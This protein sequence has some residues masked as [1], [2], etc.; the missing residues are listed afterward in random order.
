MSTASLSQMPYFTALDD[1]GVIISGAKIWTYAANSST[2]KETY[3]DYNSGTPA[4]NP[5]ICDAAGRCELWLATDGLYKLTITDDHDNLIRTVDNVG[6]GMSSGVAQVVTT[7]VGATGSLKALAVPMAGTSVIALS[8]RVGGTTGGGLFKWV[9]GASG[10]DDG[11]TVDGNSTYGTAGRWKRVISGDALDP[12]WWG[13]YGNGTDPDQSYLSNAITYALSVSKALHLT[14]GNYNLSVAVDFKSVPV[15]FD[16]IAKFTWSSMTPDMTAVIGAGDI[17]QHFSV[18]TSTAYTPKFPAGTEAIPQWFGAAGD[19]VT[20]DEIFINQAIKSVSY[21][22]GTVKVDGTYALATEIIPCDNVCIQGQGTLT[23]VIGGW[24]GAAMI[25]NNTVSAHNARIAGLT[26]NGGAGTPGVVL[27]GSN[28]VIEDCTINDAGHDGIRIGSS[29]TAMDQTGVS[30]RNNTVNR[31]GGTYGSAISVLQGQDIV[32]E[33][34]QVT[35]TKQMSV[36]PFFG[37][38]S[39]VVV[40]DNAVS[41]SGIEV[42][43][44]ATKNINNLT[45]ADNKLTGGYVLFSGACNNMSGQINVTGNSISDTTGISFNLTGTGGPDA[46]VISNN[47]ITGAN[48]GLLLTDMTHVYVQGN[49]INGLADSTG[50]IETGVSDASYAT[51]LFSSDVTDWYQ[52]VSPRYCTL[53]TDFKSQIDGGTTCT[54]LTV[55]HNLTVIGS[56]I[57]QPFFNLMQSNI[58]GLQLKNSVA[59]DATVIMGPGAGATKLGS[60]FYATAVATDMTKSLTGLWH[61]GDNTGGRASQSALTADAWYNVHLLG[62]STDTTSFDFGFDLSPDA[63]SLLIDAAGSFDTYRRIGSVLY[64]SSKVQN[65]KQQG[66]KFYWIAPT[67]EANITSPSEN[68]TVKHNFKPK[69]SP[70]KSLPIDAYCAWPLSGSS[71]YAVE[72]YNAGATGPMTGYQGTAAQASGYIPI[73]GL[74]QDTTGG[75]TWSNTEVNNQVTFAV[76][77]SGWMD[78]RGKY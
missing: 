59:V 14:Q 28:N 26:I 58:T 78:D 19:G 9:A 57:N 3:V 38:I 27:S 70:N 77:V 62:K 23:P 75:V 6:T 52:T 34:N 15:V 43:P 54:N 24:S 36:V 48:R 8:Y 49:I 46:Y 61:S 21:N 40:R 74:V 65:F 7:V 44:Q 13:C 55:E 56:I 41:G 2:L 71:A 29:S 20:A 76:I 12:Y 25:G 17:S 33:G 50:I 53:G 32:V 68:P 1:N 60:N 4:S 66:D 47:T 42:D 30:V 5:V 69:Y 18:G 10:G 22:S 64:H 63:T 51:N 72:F 37:G 39:D 11:E 35:G 31:C 73:P 67:A 16:P 45:I